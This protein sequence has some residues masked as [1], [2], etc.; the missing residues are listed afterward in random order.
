V[1]NATEGAFNFKFNGLLKLHSEAATE[2]SGRMARR[3]VG[4]CTVALHTEDSVRSGPGPRLTLR[5]A[6]AERR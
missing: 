6:D 5:L 4:V 1:N 3:R 2:V